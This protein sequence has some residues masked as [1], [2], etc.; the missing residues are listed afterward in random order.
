MRLK[1][2]GPN[3]PV[4][5]LKG[6]VLKLDKGLLNV[7]IV[8]KRPFLNLNFPLVLS[9]TLFAKKNRTYQALGTT[10]KNVLLSS[11]EITGQPMKLFFSVSSHILAKKGHRWS[12]FKIRLF[13][14]FAS[15]PI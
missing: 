2:R 6:A 1:Q 11:G 12:G 10:R 5:L 8:N 7:N 14:L 3:I 4:I 9:R 15:Y 13:T